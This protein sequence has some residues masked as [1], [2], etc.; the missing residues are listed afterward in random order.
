M[1]ITKKSVEERIVVLLMSIGI[2]IEEAAKEQK[3]GAVIK[4]IE[5]YNNL[6]EA[7]QHFIVHEPK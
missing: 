5:A 6:I 4:L 2:L 7:K 1:E 3:F